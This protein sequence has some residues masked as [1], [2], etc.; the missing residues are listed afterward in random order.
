MWKNLSRTVP[1][2]I[3]AQKA[4]LWVSLKEFLYLCTLEPSYQ[5]CKLTFE[6]KFILWLKTK[7]KG[8]NRLR[9]LHNVAEC[10]QSDT[11][12]EV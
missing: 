6:K 9:L 7:I 4:R 11:Y 8:E 1:L 5:K 10:V 12:L 2:A 3:F